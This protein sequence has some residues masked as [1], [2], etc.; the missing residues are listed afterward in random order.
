MRLAVM[1]N[2]YHA[3]LTE[4]IPEWL[5][6]LSQ[7]AE[8]TVAA[9]LA[10]HLRL[11]ATSFRITPRAQV[12]AAVDMVISLGGDGTFLAAARLVGHSE[13]PILGIKFGGL[14]F[15][16]EVGPEQLYS[17]LET[18]LA[19]KY[20]IQEKMVLQA[21]LQPGSET[22]PLFALNDIVIDKGGNARLVRMRTFVDEAYLN[23]YKAD[24]LIIAT[25]TGST[26]YSLAAGGPIL[27]PEMKAM[28]ITPICPHSL[29]DRPLVIPDDQ[30]VRVELLTSHSEVNVS[31]DGQVSMLL[32][33]GASLVI[34]KAPFTIRLVRCIDPPSQSFYDRLRHKLQ[35]GNSSRKIE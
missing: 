19:G 27:P 7:R 30:T 35:W 29:S 14:G 8:V 21:G 25:P 17:A 9:D 4:V 22:P 24:G 12:V 13:I 10:Q 18:I 16:V 28:V 15:L 31:A 1:G 2:L 23:T 11:T 33:A 5:V 32:P 34:R 6:W 26:A 3:A 20:S